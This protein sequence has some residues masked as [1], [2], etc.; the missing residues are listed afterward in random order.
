MENIPG[1]LFQGFSNVK[2]E[3]SLL[4]INEEIRNDS[5]IARL[6][7]RIEQALVENDKTKVERTKKQLPFCTLMAT[8]SEVRRP[9]GI[10]GYNPITTIDIDSL[11]DEQVV[12]LRPVIEGDVNTL[13]NFLTA[14]RHGYKIQAYLQTPEAERLRRA[15]FSATEITYGQ[16]DKYHHTMYEL[17]RSYYE[18]LLGVEVDTSGKDIGRGIFLA[19]DPDAYLNFGL[20]AQIEPIL[21]RII[22]DPEE[23]GTV[24]KVGRK[25]KGPTVTGVAASLTDVPIPD[26]IEYKKAV[27]YT[28]KK[29]KFIPGNRDMF[30]FT[31]GNRCYKKGLDEAVV[32]LLAQSEFGT[33]PDIDVAQII[34]NAYTY[35]NRTKTEQEKQE[36]TKVP[37]AQQVLAYLDTHYSF[38][39]NIVMDRL[40]YCKLATGEEAVPPSYIPIRGRDYNSIFLELQ[41]A[42]ICCYQTMMRSFI[43]SN[44]AKE[45]NPFTEYFHSL[46]KWNRRTDY[47]QQLADTVEAADQEF[48]STSLKRWLVGT[49]ACALN[50]DIQNQLVLLLYSGQ[51]RGKSTWIRRLVPPELK[52]YYCNKIIDSNDKDEML[53][54]SSHLFINLDEFETDRPGSMAA[55]KRIIS[56]D[57]I[58]ERKVYDTQTAQYIRRASFIA[59][60]NNPHCLTDTG[61]NRRFLTSELKKIEYRAKLNYEGIY[62]QALAL[63]ES[64]YQYWY[65]GY[66]IEMLNQRNEQHRMK[67]PV[68]E[69]LYIYFRP[70]TDTDT[71]MIWKPAA[72]LLSVISVYGR[73]QANKSSLLILTQILERDGF[74]RRINE[75]GVTEYAVVAF[76]EHEVEENSKKR[77]ENLIENSTPKQES[78]GMQKCESLELTF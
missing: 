75:H 15:T 41:L 69:N 63:L 2:E 62:S 57:Y 72:G 4:R 40:E 24:K 7:E 37:A 45:F 48:W 30:L 5:Y 27:A 76:T 32:K 59:S 9:S 77:V 23:N 66:E 56:Q 52:E 58:T 67:D 68:E 6:N 26:K 33:E 3:T 50:D 20:L 35:T 10:S 43:D 61:G 19:H 11:T 55:L 65:E 70:T 8:Y 22:P 17:C 47:I 13:H 1:T 46:K 73:T 39:H 28:Q 31:L 51:G 36:Q 64:G 42:G 74:K 25:P 34:H 16:L 53:M 12:T 44:Y 60:T 78:D 21:T 49:V 14:K 38:R 29:E 18:R 54:L 71:H